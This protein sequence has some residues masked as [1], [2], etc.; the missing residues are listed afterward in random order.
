MPIDPETCGQQK[1][2]FEIGLA[3]GQKFIKNQQ[4]D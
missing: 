1:A 2:A 3:L 4:N